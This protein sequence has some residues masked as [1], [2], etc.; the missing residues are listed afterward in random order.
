MNDLTELL[1]SNKEHL[2]TCS[3]KHSPKNCLHN[4]NMSIYRTKSFGSNNF[5]QSSMGSIL[6]HWSIFQVPNYCS[7]TTEN[8]RKL[9]SFHMFHSKKDSSNSTLNLHTSSSISSDY[10]WKD[11]I[12]RV[13]VTKFPTFS[14]FAKGTLYLLTPTPFEIEWDKVVSN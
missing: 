3:F 11:R 10:Q 5:H 8:L 13:N 1:F 7:K 2:W 9:V 6:S 14:M 4:T 12:E